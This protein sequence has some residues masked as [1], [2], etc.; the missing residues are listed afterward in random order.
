M[1]I[2][3]NTDA[4]C[5]MRPIFFNLSSTLMFAP[6][7]MKLRRVN[8]LVHNPHLKKIVIKDGQVLL[9]VLGLLFIDGLLL[10][11]WAVF[12]TPRM[13]IVSTGKY[14][15]VYKT[16]T[17]HVCSTGLDNYFE[18]IFILY[19]SGLIASG[20]Y[21]AANAWN[22]TGDLLEAKYFAIAIYNITM[23]GGL[24]YFLSIYLLT[25]T[26]VVAAVR[27][28]LAYIPIISFESLV[29][30]VGYS[31]LPGPFPSLCC[32]CSGDN[33]PQ[34]FYQ[35]EYCCSRVSNWYWFWSEQQSMDA[36]QSIIGT[37]ISP[38][39]REF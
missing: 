8:M 10:L 34:T 11:P 12:E 30:V 1:N 24:S 4:T 33:I 6:L 22:V 39:S 26:G 20:I 23:L 38:F 27:D 25:N 15:G 5:M 7:V 18:I 9:Q 31:S 35:R 19:K 37:Y 17:D 32:G 14:S 28:H 2:G 29:L 3:P 13:I 36:Q 16:I 21:Q